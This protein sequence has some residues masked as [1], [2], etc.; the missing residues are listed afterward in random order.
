VVR[1]LRADH[2]AAVGAQLGECPIW[3]AVL[4]IT[5]ATG[6]PAEKLAPPLAGNLFPVCPDVNRP[7]R[8]SVAPGAAFR[9]GVISWTCLRRHPVGSA[10]RGVSTTRWDGQQQVG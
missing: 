4:Y 7:C 5:T 9:S 8:Q 2:V 1:I 6:L 3:D 10:L